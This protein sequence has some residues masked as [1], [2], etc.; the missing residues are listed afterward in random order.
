MVIRRAADFEHT[1]LAA[2]VVAHAGALADAD[3]PL[4][5]APTE[6]AATFQSSHMKLPTVAVQARSLIDASDAGVAAL[7][8]I[9]C[10]DADARACWAPRRVTALG[11]RLRSGGDGTSPPAATLLGK[12]ARADELDASPA[13]LAAS[14][15]RQTWHTRTARA[16][17]RG[18]AQP[19][20]AEAAAAATEAAR[21]ALAA[22]GCWADVPAERLE[23]AERLLKAV[24]PRFSAHRIGGSRRRVDAVWRILCMCVVH[25]Q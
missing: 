5:R 17:L 12:R 4:E 22:Q 13:E 9:E 10:A 3:A 18:R 20:A 16:A 23:E 11:L 2:L 6:R 8:A 1:T 21:A 14:R 25:G 19:P 24:L 7:V 15:A